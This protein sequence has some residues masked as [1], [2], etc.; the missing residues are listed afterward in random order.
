ME[1]TPFKYEGLISETMTPRDVIPRMVAIL[2]DLNPAA[3]AK[4]I[5]PYAKTISHMEKNEP[6][7][8]TID[9]MSELNFM[10][11]DLIDGLQ[12]VTPKGYILEC[13][14]NDPTKPWGFWKE[15]EFLGM[16]EEEVEGGEETQAAAV[17]IRE[18]EAA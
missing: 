4:A 7:T 5:D 6:H 3:Q 9:F 18:G 14:D 16:F 17:I 10:L 13:Q 1:A 11:D 8:W 15:D 2:K 12:A